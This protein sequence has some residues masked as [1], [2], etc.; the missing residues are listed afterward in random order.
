V[1]IDRPASGVGGAPG[2]EG[3][4]DRWH[5]NLP[6]HGRPGSTSG[7]LTLRWPPRSGESHFDPRTLDAL[8]DPVFAA[9]R[10][11]AEETGGWML[12][13]PWDYPSTFDSLARRWRVWIHAAD[14]E[15][16]ELHPVTVTLRKGPELRASRWLR[17]ATPGAVAEARLRAALDSE[18]SAS[19]KALAARV[20]RDSAGSVVLEVAPDASAP[21]TTV[22]RWLVGVEGADGAVL[23]QPAAPELRDGAWRMRLSVPP[24]TRLLA[25]SRDDVHGEAYGIAVLKPPPAPG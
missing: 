10:L 3:D 15:A 7:A 19:G 23:I 5:R 24:G 18:R 1:L 17:S 11:L 12:A 25:V 8:L 14:D 22:W 6:D 20:S 2:V 9:P 21:P 4:F 13:G 16:G